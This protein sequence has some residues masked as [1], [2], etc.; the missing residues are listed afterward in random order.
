[1]SDCIR[2][3]GQPKQAYLSKREAKTVAR[4]VRGRHGYQGHT[5][6]HIYRCTNGCG[7]WHLGHER[8]IA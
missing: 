3:N 1:M 6:I 4:I 8:G 2:G 5:P 7:Y